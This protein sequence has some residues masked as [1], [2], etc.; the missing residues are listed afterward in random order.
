MPEQPTIEALI[1]YA[2]QLSEAAA[3]ASAASEKQ[4]QIINGNAQTDVLTESGPVPSFAKQAVQAQ[5]KVTEVLIDVA[6]R[7]AGP[8]PYGSVVLGLLNTVSGGYFNVLS[9]EASEITIMYLNNNGVPVE[10]KRASSAAADSLLLNAGKDFPL[11]AATRGE[12]DKT[13]FVSAAV[14]SVNA[15]RLQEL[16]ATRLLNRSG[17]IVPHRN[18]LLHHLTHHFDRTFEIEA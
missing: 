13:P 14:A 6:S 18:G 8:L 12:K 15:G 10:V 16:S 17:S 5:A 11:R 9:P 4:H 7:M 2:G 1:A 3:Q